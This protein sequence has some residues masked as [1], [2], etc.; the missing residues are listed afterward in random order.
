M[1]GTGAYVDDVQ[2]AFVTQLE[3]QLLLQVLPIVVGMLGV[4]LLI[5]R[6]VERSI[7]SVTRTLEAGDLATRLDE[8]NGKTELDQLAKR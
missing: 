4:G 7:K 1:I 3:R 6:R 8:G 2:T 5:A